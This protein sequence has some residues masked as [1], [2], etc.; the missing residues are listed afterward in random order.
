MGFHIYRVAGP[1]L[2]RGSYALTFDGEG[3][4]LVGDGNSVRRLD[5]VDGDGVYDQFETIATGLGPR[6]PQGLLIWGDRLYAVGG[7]GL[8]VFDGY[9]SGKL[10]RRGRLGGA[11]NTGGDHD[12]H[13]VLRGHDGFLYLMAGNGAGVDGRKHITEASSPMLQERQASVFRLDPDGRHWECLAAGGR[14]PPGLGLNYLGELFSFD[15]DME[16]HVG[17]PWYRPIRL[18]HWAT[19][20][21]QGWEEVGAR[22][23]YFIDAAT[24]V[25]EAGRGSPTCGV[26]YEH[27][28]FPAH[29]RNAFFNC[30]Y[31]WKRESDDQYATTGRLVAFF[32]E[33][34]GAEWKARMETVAKPKP[35]ARDARGM[36]IDFALVDVAVAP[37]G[38]LFLSD[39]RQG[40][41][42]LF[43]GPETNPSI[44][45]GIQPDRGPLPTGTTA[46]L[47]ELLRLPQPLSEWSRA[48]E[49]A[50]GALGGAV[51]TNALRQ[52]A[53]DAGKPL[54]ERVRAVQ[55]LAPE[56][57]G[58]DAA[59]LTGLVT[60][61]DPEIR[62]QAGWLLGL[63]MRTEETPLLLKLLADTHPLVRRRAAESL[64]RS[65]VAA[66]AAGL[67]TRLNDESRLTRFIAMNALARHPLAEWFPSASRSPLIQTRLRSLVAALLGRETPPD[68]QVREV[69]RPLL[70]PGHGPVSAEDRTDFLRVLQLF[71]RSLSADPEFRSLVEHYVLSVFPASVARIRWEQAAVAGLYRL[72]RSFGPLTRWLKSERDPV[73]QFRIAKSLARLRSGW[74]V[75]EETAAVVWFE[76]TQTGWFA[77]FAS[78][79]VE[80][81]AF[82]ATTVKEFSDHHAEAVL[83]RASEIDV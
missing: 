15:S 41:W 1:E 79:G 80:F 69:L 7:D 33:R 31:R 81:P 28:Q 39:H 47:G 19:G 71:E 30:D 72:D 27:R 16:W 66:A 65:D 2:T 29:Y 76:G 42:R 4:L 21:D 9:R 67:V 18:N 78:K 34:D 43:Y 10:A 46:I 25:M 53:S 59:W 8:Q 61:R 24:P 54:E 63:R 11:F 45:P 3:R 12:L 52:A 75:D 26:F 64:N 23:D 82:W 35:N 68:E 56:F 48:R 73:T 5:D 44:I 14:N 13:A 17:L 60:D 40:V 22:P 20:T 49:E 50:L 6:G 58:L 83:R 70:Q 77:D 38:S 37:D 32:L 36:L 55:L 51:L 74:T 57:A 62:A